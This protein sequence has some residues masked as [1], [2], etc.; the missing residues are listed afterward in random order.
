MGAHSRGAGCFSPAR[1]KEG[2][3]VN[4]VRV[5]STRYQQRTNPSS[6][7]TQV[8]DAMLVRGVEVEERLMD[9]VMWDLVKGGR[10]EEGGWREEK[11]SWMNG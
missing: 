1:W 9:A 8:L 10:W 7:T 2:Q 6:S 3:S 11:G 4:N 5:F